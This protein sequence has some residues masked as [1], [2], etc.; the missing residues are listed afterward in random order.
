MESRGDEE[1]ID[2]SRKMSLFC[3]T[4]LDL[5]LKILENKILSE[6]KRLIKKEVLK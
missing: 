4:H 5:R 1:M 3:A 6:V 2:P